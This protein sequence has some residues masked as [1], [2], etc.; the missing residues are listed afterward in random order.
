MIDIIDV[1]VQSNLCT[2]ATLGTE[3]IKAIVERWL[4]WERR[5]VTWDL[6][7]SLYP[8]DF[9]IIRESWHRWGAP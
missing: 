2:M 8:G 3:E 7:F 9:Q 6:F 1:Q 5:G 4:L